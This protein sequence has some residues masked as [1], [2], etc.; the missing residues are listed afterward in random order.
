MSE[1]WYV[2]HVST[3][4]EDTVR[5]YIYEQMKLDKCDGMIADVLVPTETIEEQLKGGK[6]NHR[7]E[8]FPLPIS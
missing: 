4:F 6:R 3:S 5:R 2:V 7:K 8:I 1:K